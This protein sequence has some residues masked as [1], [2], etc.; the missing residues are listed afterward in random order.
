MVTRSKLLI[1]GGVFLVNFILMTNIGMELQPRNFIALAHRRLM[2]C[3]LV[4]GQVVVVPLLGL[5]V[6]R[7]LDLPPPLTAGILLLAACPVGDIANIYTLLGRG[8]IALSVSL[9]VS[10]CLLSILT[11]SLAFSLYDYLLGG[12]FMFAVPTPALVS[13]LLVMVVVPVVTGMLLRR[14]AP[15]WSLRWSTILRKI[16]VVGVS[17]LILYVLATQKQLITDDWR[18]IAAASLA[19]MM[20]ALLTGMAFGRLLRLPA[21]DLLTCGIVFAVRNVALA[22]AIAVTILNRVEYAAFS[23]VYFLTEVPLLLLFAGGAQRWQRSG[24][25]TKP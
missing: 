18:V 5:L 8:N 11:M 14:F 20:L 21:A 15:A 19:F 17:V 24:F 1:D 22:M 12:Q 23:L 6:A 7:T 9:N 16:S 3:T 10:T 13:R 4:A 2:S 25:A